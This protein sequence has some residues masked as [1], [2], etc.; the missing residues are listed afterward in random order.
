MGWRGSVETNQS[1]ILSI[2]KSFVM[3]EIFM[4]GSC[5]FLAFTCGQIARALWVIR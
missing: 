4:L 3:L 2:E 1:I 5:G